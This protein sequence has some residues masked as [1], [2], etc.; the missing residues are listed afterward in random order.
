MLGIIGAMDVEVAKLKERMT[1]V[2]ITK[3]AS[4]EFYKGKLNRAEAVVVR[5]GV[6]KVNAACCAQALIDRFPVSCVINTG[7]AGSLRAEI[8]IGDVVLATDAVE[9]D[10]DASIFG[11]APG[12][13]PGMD[14][15]AFAADAALRRVA[16][17]SCEKSIRISASMRGAV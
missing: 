11:Y 13:V 3:A 1:D 16:R 14:A 12:K 9:H 17:E 4:M 10:M 5:A 15:E 2:E 6:G 8:D 7:I